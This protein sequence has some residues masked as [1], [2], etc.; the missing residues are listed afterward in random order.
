[1]SG[2]GTIGKSVQ[3]NQLSQW[4][5][6]IQCVIDSVAWPWELESRVKNVVQFVQVCP[7]HLSAAWHLQLLPRRTSIEHKAAC[8]QQ[9]KLFVNQGCYPFILLCFFFQHWQRCV[10]FA[11]SLV[12]LFWAYG[13]QR[14]S[15]TRTPQPSP[16]KMCKHNQHPTKLFMTDTT[17]PTMSNKK[18]WAGVKGTSNTFGAADASLACLNHFVCCPDAIPMSTVSIDQHILSWNA[19]HTKLITVWT[20]VT[21]VSRSVGVKPSTHVYITIYITPP[22]ASNSLPGF[23]H[24][25]AM[26]TQTYVRF[27]PCLRERGEANPLL[28][29]QKTSWAS[30]VK[31]LRK[32]EW[33]CRSS[34]EN[35]WKCHQRRSWHT[36]WVSANQRP[37]PLGHGQKLRRLRN[38]VMSTYD[39]NSFPQKG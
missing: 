10:L 15:S 1:M 36:C 23:I 37:T 11:S 39:C 6:W 24:Q 34:N 28:N 18:K 3:G 14:A 5:T 26:V 12:R 21:I 25:R 17:L 20:L 13:A 33:S 38:S 22:M 31:C 8:T 35:V 9:D 29:A 30:K 27:T 7:S 19:K 4:S 16:A 2:S 32:D